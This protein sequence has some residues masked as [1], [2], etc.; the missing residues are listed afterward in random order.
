L[1]KRQ[2]DLNV[3]SFKLNGYF[4][5]TIIAYLS[6]IGGGFE[7]NLIEDNE[8]IL[9]QSN[10]DAL[11]DDL[12]SLLKNNFDET[13]IHKRPVKLDKDLV[14]NLNR[15]FLRLK[16]KS[17]NGHSIMSN[18]LRLIIKQKYPTLNDDNYY[19]SDKYLKLILT[20]FKD[21][22]TKLDDLVNIK[23]NEFLWN[24]MSSLTNDDIQIDKHQMKNLINYL[25]TEMTS[26]IAIDFFN[27]P[28]ESN[29]NEFKKLI[30]NQFKQMVKSDDNNKSIFKSNQKSINYW[31]LTRLV[32][33]GNVVGLPIFELFLLFKRDN[34][35]QRLNVAENYI[36]LLK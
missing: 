16:L 12:L 7:A 11:V 30:S 36:H 5:E 24:D 2:N 3:L 26:Q 18:E 9:T 22:V 1:S 23:D 33:T 28:T 34:I 19:L 32:L 6:K 20:T 8:E 15:F 4:P 21:R 17:K 35:E 13:K 14:D 29:E 10:Y 27:N 31:Q 25:K